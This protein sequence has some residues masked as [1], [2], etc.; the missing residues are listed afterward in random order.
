[1][2]GLSR[3]YLNITPGSVV[4]EG[5]VPRVLLGGMESWK[6]SSCGKSLGHWKITLDEL[7]GF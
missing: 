5:W 7:V 2:A 4:I 3:G 6:V 1:M